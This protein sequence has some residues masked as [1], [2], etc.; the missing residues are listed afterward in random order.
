MKA[1]LESASIARTRLSRARSTL[2][3][4]R[5]RVLARKR[6]LSHSIARQ[7]APVRWM[8]FARGRTQPDHAGAVADRRNASPV[9]QR[10]DQAGATGRLQIRLQQ[11]SVFPVEKLRT[12]YHGTAAFD[13]TATPE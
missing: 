3:S 12:R 13:A 1:E 2:T 10:R 6:A 8:L 11:Q 4:Q 7:L 5:I 9:P